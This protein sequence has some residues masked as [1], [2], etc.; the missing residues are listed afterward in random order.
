MGH[1]ALVIANISLTVVALL[2]LL[3]LFDI[4]IPSVGQTAS[5]F[6]S[7]TPVCYVEW[8]HQLTFWND[9]PQCCLQAR[10]Q[11]S[12]VKDP[13]AYLDTPLDWNCLTGES[14]V[15]YRLNNKAYNYCSRQN[16]WS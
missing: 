1:K 5:F 3:S 16:F 10:Q 13:A 9:L 12:C 11:L 14:T 7:S 15:N 8:Q 6:D 4:T 2:L